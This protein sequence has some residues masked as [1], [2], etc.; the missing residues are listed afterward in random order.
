MRGFT[1][2]AAAVAAVGM[3]GTATAAQA[4]VLDHGRFSS[5]ESVGP[6]LISDLPCLEGKEFMLTGTE[7]ISGQFVE[8]ANGFHV[9]FHEKH[10]GTAVPVDGQGPT[11]VERGNADHTAFTDRS[12][13]GNGQVTLT[14]VNNDNFFGFEDGKLVASATIRIHELEHFVAVDTDG[15][16]QPDTVKVD[17]AIDNVSCP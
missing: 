17:F 11:Y 15:D 9:S 16:G 8:R 2:A 7:S 12:L 4:T 5:D 6:M 13:V 3:C 1:K 10:T 14:H